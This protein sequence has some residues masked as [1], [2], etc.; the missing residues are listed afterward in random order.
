MRALPHGQGP[1]LLTQQFR[2]VAL[3]AV[4][5][6]R[7]FVTVCRVSLLSNIP[8]SLHDVWLWHGSWK[9]N[10]QSPLKLDLALE[11]RQGNA[12]FILWWKNSPLYIRLLFLMSSYILLLQPWY[13]CGTS[14]YM[15]KS[16]KQINLVGKRQWS[17]R[18]S[19]CP[20]DLSASLCCVAPHSCVTVATVRPHYTSPRGTKNQAL[21]G[22]CGLMGPAGETVLIWEFWAVIFTH[23]DSPAFAVSS[24]GSSSRQSSSPYIPSKAWHCCSSCIPRR[25][26]WMPST[27]LLLN[28]RHPQNVPSG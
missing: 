23:F 22:S 16:Q 21:F 26:L 3:S 17:S 27:V 4:V 11:K 20:V 28:P 9:T 5:Y 25:C 13:G 6:G 24:P 1:A 10:K 2:A 12:V 7:F 18:M 14:L 15:L 8:I 19:E